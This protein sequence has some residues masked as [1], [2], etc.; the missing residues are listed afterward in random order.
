MK[1]DEFD[2]REA[3]GWLYPKIEIVMNVMDA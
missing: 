3:C 2:F 1:L